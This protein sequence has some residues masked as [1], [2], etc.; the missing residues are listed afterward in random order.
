MIPWYKPSCWRECRP[1]TCRG[2]EPRGWFGL[3]NP[4]SYT[5]YP[6]QGDQGAEISPNI[7][8]N[9]IKFHEYF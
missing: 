7:S 8:I 3:V 2:V 6:L 4:P 9:Q 5:P 1:R